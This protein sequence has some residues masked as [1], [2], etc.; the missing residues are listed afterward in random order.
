MSRPIPRMRDRY[1][2]FRSID[3]RWND[4]DR[5]GHINNAIF[6]ELFDTTVNAWLVENG[7]FQDDA[8]P[9][10]VVARQACDYFMEIKL[11]EKVEVGLAVEAIGTSSISY[12]PALFRVG[13]NQPA[14]QGQYIHVAVDRVTRRPRPI[15]SEV[16]KIFENLVIATK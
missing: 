9:M 11:A 3:L 6:F 14:A 12:I 10:C 7:L 13:E 4:V 8:D 2:Y 5:Y 1:R 15:G 16:I